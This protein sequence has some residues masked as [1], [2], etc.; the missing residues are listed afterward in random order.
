MADKKTVSNKTTIEAEADKVSIVTEIKA[1]GVTSKTYSKL[2]NDGT[3]SVKET[4]ETKLFKLVVGTSATT[5][6]NA[7]TGVTSSS[8]EDFVYLQKEF[9]LGGKQFKAKA[10]INVVADATSKPAALDKSIAI[11]KT[12]LYSGLKLELKISAAAG[13]EFKVEG[14]AL[15]FGGTNSNIRSEDSFSIL[16][17][18]TGSASVTGIPL[19]KN[20]L[21]LSSQEYANAQTRLGNMIDSVKLN[22]AYLA[23]NSAAYQAASAQI[24]QY[25]QSKTNLK[26]AEVFSVAEVAEKSIRAGDGV[27]SKT[28]TDNG[29]RVLWQNTDGTKLFADTGTE[30]VILVRADGSGDAFSYTLAN[31]QPAQSFKLTSGATAAISV[32]PDGMVRVS[33]GQRELLAQGMGSL[34]LSDKS[35]NTTT[36]WQL[37][38]N[39]QY[40]R[41]TLTGTLSSAAALGPD[42]YLGEITIIGKRGD[43]INESTT[44][45]NSA[46]YITDVNA[47]DHA[48]VIKTG[49]TVWDVYAL[50]KNDST[51]FKSWDE[52][53]EAIAASNPNIGDLNKIPTGAT[54]YL[55]EKLKD[56]SITYNY[57]NGVSLNSNRVNGEYHMLVP[58]GSGGT[59]VYSRKADDFGYTVREVHTD[60]L[61]GVT[62]DYTGTQATLDAEI[63]PLG[64]EWNNSQETGKVQVFANNSSITSVED[65]VTGDITETVKDSQQ[66]VV[67]SKTYDN[68][69]AR[70][71]AAQQNALLAGVELFDAIRH[72]NNLGAVSAITRL[73]NESRIAADQPIV[74]APQVGAVLGLIGALDLFGDAKTDAQKFVATARLVLSANTTYA[75]FNEGKSFLDAGTGLTSPLMASPNSPTRGHP[76]FP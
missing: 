51:G 75:A 3:I 2:G 53:K 64:F 30:R 27:W 36:Y 15:S 33:D 66:N 42:A 32:L 17:S 47:N 43:S 67:E 37:K 5:S 31:T 38:E 25:V 52:F 20:F 44:P 35:S 8:A 11:V 49:G 73:V 63:K 7:L 22:Q 40:E 9:E 10:S 23:P 50:Q 61:G 62:L 68:H 19:N 6:S 55:P 21:E 59:I 54:I 74:F 26:T 28:T 56:G 34:V 4:V 46:S 48:V 45:R 60:K 18:T 57:A 65:K 14:N 58:D 41:R 72:K 13:N 16:T 71:E 24:A 39:G 76:K 69:T 1:G 70:V 29:Q 12:D